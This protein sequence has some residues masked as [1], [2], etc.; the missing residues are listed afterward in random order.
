MEFQINLKGINMNIFRKFLA[1]ILALFVSLN[2]HG[3]TLESEVYGLINISHDS[4]DNVDDD[5]RSNASRLGIKGEYILG[6]SLSL[7]YQF[8]QDIDYAHG[9]TN[10][11]TLFGMRDSFI[12]VR[13][14]F[15]DI[16]WGAHD[17]P[18]HLARDNIDLFNDQIGDIKFLVE[19]EIR[20]TDSLMYHS[21][22]I[23]ENF[24]I[25]AMYIPSDDH[26]DASY[27]T[28][29]SFQSGDWYAALAVDTDMRENNKTT[30]LT[31]A[32]DSMR[33]V[34]QFSPGNWRLAF[35]FQ[36]TEYLDR[37]NA[38]NENG[39]VVSAG[40]R[41]NNWDFV[42]QHGQSDIIEQ[43][44]ESSQ[45]GASYHVSDT[46]KVYLY[47]VQYD[48]DVISDDLVSVGFQ[49]NF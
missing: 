49:I 47:T 35:L 36:Q 4:S 12:G 32:Y 2:G 48:D 45:L 25:R 42:F 19:G 46:L 23:A 27:S 30:S 9:G 41:L 7:V 44:A 15:G 37:L 34:T 8:E 38:E 22:A 29:F 24:H 1:C 16:L 31:S 18:F 39:F 5:W 13:G 40:Y 11:E 21:P 6:D 10:E 33:L 28:S 26:F 17:T 14:N 43:G 3:L 20:T